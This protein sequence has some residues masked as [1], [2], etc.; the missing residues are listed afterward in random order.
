VAGTAKLLDRDGG[1]QAVRTFGLP[2][3]LVAPVAVALPVAEL[4]VAVALIDTR[5]AVAGA[6][7]AAILLAGFIAGIAITLGQGN[8][9][10]C[11][12]F[13]SLHS[14]TVGRKTIVRDAALL[15]GAL[16]VAVA[17][18]GTGLSAWASGVSPIDWAA[19]VVGITLAIAFVV[20][21]SQLVQRWC[22]R[23]ARPSSP[24]YPQKISTVGEKPR[25]VSRRS[26]SGSNGR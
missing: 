10:D 26:R 18:P 13:G 12:C 8:Q 2:G 3:P 14:A 21:G 15:A 23:S 22:H 7:G 1:R 4:A 9:P 17:G 25:W 5:S 24:G 20:E 16:L 19:I 11:R 6:W